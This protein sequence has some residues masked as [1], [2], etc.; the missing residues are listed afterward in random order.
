MNK[1]CFKKTATIAAITC[2]FATG[3]FYQS[4]VG[5]SPV[6]QAVAQP[7]SKRAELPD[8]AKLVE[9]NGKAVVSIKVA[10][11]GG[12][13][14]FHGNFKGIPKDKLDELRKF[15][16]PF[17]DFDNEQ[18]R[19]APK[20]QGQG[21]GFIITPDG[22]ILTNHH[23]VDGADEIKVHLSD[24]RE[25]P[26]KVIGSDAKTDVAVIKID[27]KD[28]PTVKLGKS[29]DVR[30]GEW[31]A[32]IGAPFGLE[33][34]VTSGIV[35]AKSRDLPS[36]QFVPFIQTDAAVNPGN[37]GGPLFNMDGEVI[38]I[39][40]QIFSTSGG[41]MGLSFAIPIDLALQ[42][43][44][45]LVQHGRVHRGRLGVMIQN[46][47]PDLAQ[48]LGLENIKGALISQVEKDSAAEKAGLTDG[49]IVI[50]FA[51]K[52]IT[53]PSDLSR[54]VASA[55]PGTEHVIKIIREGKEQTVKVTLAEAPNDDVPAVAQ[56][57][58]GRL[59]V[60]VRPLNDE[61][62]KQ[63]KDGLVI[64][65]SE[66]AAAAAGLKAGDII[67]GVGGKK[68]TS[69][70]QFKKAVNDAKSILALQVIRDGQRSFIAVKLDQE[71]EEKKQTK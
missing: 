53:S 38:G 51:G 19:P 70:E 69:F 36:D 47:T 56:Q 65:E 34:T 13:S 40:S 46:I 24:D 27:A 28:L 52:P 43:K 8:F 29:S 2:A 68:V 37:S 12:S 67:I 44:D 59:G 25:L 3:V 66:G 62:K 14:G 4:S 54:S 42:I 64:V 39:N 21:S 58:K 50:E 15:G 17:P 16:F 49:D 26:A 7:V 45:D 48:G 20:R 57:S 63:Y 71:Q 33:N 9:E 22:M 18:P 31:V 6:S 5:I 32:A 61:E 1:S 10:K 35:S 23:V 55:K 60:S 41:F 11:K 30:V